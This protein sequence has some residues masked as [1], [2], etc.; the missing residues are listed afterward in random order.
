MPSTNPAFSHEFANAMFEMLPEF[1]GFI[2]SFMVIGNT[3]NRITVHFI[4]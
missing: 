1:I 2:I 3:G 4:L